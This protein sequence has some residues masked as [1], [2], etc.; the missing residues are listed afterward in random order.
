MPI[1]QPL[2]LWKLLE[3]AACYKIV[4]FLPCEDFKHLFGVWIQVQLIQLVL[5]HRQYL[6]QA[7]DFR[8]V[9]K[10]FVRSC[11]GFENVVNQCSF[12]ILI[13][14]TQRLLDISVGQFFVGI[15]VK[16]GVCVHFEEPD[17]EVLINKNVKAKYLKR[18]W[19][20]MVCAYKA[21]VSVFKVRLKCNNSLLRHLFH[22]F[23]K[24]SNILSFGDEIF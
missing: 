17:V 8:D 5:R 2:V 6:F 1:R 19:R 16:W 13:K 10:L 21:M 7:A 20:P 3:L 15:D 23:L 24:M 9:W 14:L 4:T 12:N 22:L 11:Y 18:S